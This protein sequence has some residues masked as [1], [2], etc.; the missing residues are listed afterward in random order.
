MFCKNTL[1]IQIK[2][3]KKTPYLNQQFNQRSILQLQISSSHLNCKY[4]IASWTN[5]GIYAK[6]W[7]QI[8]AVTE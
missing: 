6:F 4:K 1:S 8:S 7:A 5:L 2:V 3:I